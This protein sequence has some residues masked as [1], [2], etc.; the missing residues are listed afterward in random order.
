MKPTP[1][2]LGGLDVERTNWRRLLTPPAQLTYPSRSNV[3][4]QTVAPGLDLVTINDCRERPMERT[5]RIGSGYSQLRV[6]GSGAPRSLRERDLLGK[7][8]FA[9]FL[10]GPGSSEAIW[11]AATFDDK[12]DPQPVSGEEAQEAVQARVKNFE[13]QWDSYRQEAILATLDKDV[14][15]SAAS[16]PFLSPR[17]SRGT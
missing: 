8:T 7:P 2:K 17:L 15:G 4:V 3:D 9:A 6:D 10:V 16:G 14:F 5:I 12:G 1:L 13:G 11:V